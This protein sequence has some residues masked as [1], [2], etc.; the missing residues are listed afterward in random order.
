M[1]IRISVMFNKSN[2]VYTST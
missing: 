1:I 2:I